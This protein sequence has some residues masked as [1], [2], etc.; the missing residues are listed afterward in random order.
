M[1][2]MTQPPSRSRAWRDLA[3]IS[4]A[5]VALLWVGTTAGWFPAARAWLAE[6]SSGHAADLLLIAGA[7]LVAVLV[8]AMLRWRASARTAR[9]HGEAEMRFQRLV[10]RM[11]SIT[12]TWD[13][14]GGNA[15]S[16]YVSPQV[17][18]VLGIPPEMWVA[19]PTRRIDRV[20][21]E[22]RDRVLE[23]LQR[24]LARGESVSV[25]YRFLRGDG[26]VLWIR[27]DAITIERDADG[28]PSL[29]QG[30]LLDVTERRRAEQQLEETEGRY[31]TLVERVPAVTYVWDTKYSSGEAPAMY[32][33]P[34]VRQLLG[35]GPEAFE[36]PL[37]WTRLVHPDDVDRVLA[38]WEACERG[39]VA[40]RSEYRMQSNDGRVVWVRDE[41]VPIARDDEGHI[42]FQGVM[43]DITDRKVAEERLL[44][45]ETRYRSLVEHMP[46]VAYLVDHVADPPERYV[47]PGVTELTGYSQG[48]WI[49]DPH[50]WSSILHPDD[51]RRVL[52]AWDVATNDGAPF[53]G[54][55]RLIARDG[56]VVWVLDDARPVE[57]GDQS[58]SFV[59]QGVLVDVTARMEAE[60]RVRDAEQTYRTLVEQLPVA[61]YQDAID[62]ASTAVYLSPQYERLFG[63]TVEERLADPWFW[64][65]HLHPDDRERITAESDRTNETG[66]RFVEEY[67]FL[68][69]DGTYRWVR[70][71]AVLLRE[72]D[73]TPRV[74]QGVLIDIDERRRSEETLSRRD[75]ILDAVA[76][77]AERFLRSQDAT[78]ALPAVLERLGTAANVS[79]S[80]VFHNRLVEDELAMD[81]A[82][83]WEGVGIA[84]LDPEV[85]HGLRYTDGFLRWAEVLRAGGGVHGPVREF[86]AS[87]RGPLEREEVRSLAIVPIV[88]GDV[89]WGFLGFDDCVDER[90][91]SE[92]ELEALRAASDT[93]GAAIGRA[94][95][96]TRRRDAEERYRTLVETIPAVTY[97]QDADA[98]QHAYYVSPQIHGMLGYHPEEWAMSLDEWLDTVHP[99]DRQ[100]V[101]EADAVS[102]ETGEPFAVEYRQRHKDGHYL[103]VRDETVLVR[104]AGGKPLFWQGVL[105]DI[106]AEREAEQQ[107]RDAEHRYRALVEHIPAVLYIDPV[108]EEEPTIYVSPRVEEILGIT[109][110][111]YL[112]EVDRWRELIHPDDREWVFE[113]YRRSLAERAGWA[114]EY[115]VIRPDGRM[116]WLRDESAV[117]PDSDG[118]PFV[119]QGV[120]YDVTERKLAEEALLSSER[121][122]REAAERLRALDEMK[123]TFLAAVSHELRSP[124]TSILGLALTLEQQELP[125]DDARD[126][127]HRL[128]QNARKLDRLLRDLLDIDRL[129]RGIVTPVR[130]PTDIG[131]L[132]RRTVES[133][134][135]P[136]SRHIRVD[137]EEI[138]IDVDA[139]KV[140]RIVE[141]LVMNAMRHTDDGAS[142]WIRVIEE[143]GGVLV[144]V[145]DDGP[146]VPADLREE[147]FEPFRQGPTIARHSPGTG[148]GLSL[149]AMFTELHGGRAWVEDRFGGGASFRVFLPREAED[150]VLPTGAD[151]GR[152]SAL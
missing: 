83:E 45:A 90:V 146:G 31:R 48:E 126:L 137:T 109:Q 106:T 35:Y 143:P 96:E 38:E 72:A 9:T 122:E 64:V 116:I 108:R 124:L 121:R 47:A 71:E 112:N 113:A 33:S 102:E 23:T 41:A 84:P 81:V 97:M 100:R 117:L 98:G 17:R 118:Q 62:E 123:N 152:A 53:R 28:R 105:F 18:S 67:R 92:A 13:P 140:E 138:V 37:L 132:A 73:G 149:V 125:P 57:R 60:Q 91:W 26:E 107:V 50:L 16:W 15:R 52:D 95:A 99:D 68:T 12:Y 1:T 29:V 7:V 115:R 135:L 141:N 49:S 114:V 44:A 101:E 39:D 129:S 21:E 59:W 80:Y 27:E 3:V 144:A 25:E 139:A 58:G 76:F 46:V 51:R 40:F 32:I 11:P 63:Y 148:I 145:E 69:R 2:P 134:D 89:W 151:L 36:D 103:W 4:L 20:H 55:Y 14:R 150:G 82:A 88:V 42:T 65:D 147:I 24:G 128:A 8:F 136:S 127:N 142:I 22:D 30:V 130:H 120:M 87:E 104:D 85:N 56:H 10:E 78:T 111:E 19:D 94:D 110:D 61:V 5:L 77:A 6:R 54:E 79:R 34:Q 75:A 119:F 86:P 43:F 74:W 70:D 66:E 133:L 131:E 93:L